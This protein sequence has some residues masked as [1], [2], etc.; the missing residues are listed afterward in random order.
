MRYLETEDLLESDPNKVEDDSGEYVA[1]KEKLS[2]NKTETSN[3]T[4]S[5][6]DLDA[7]FIEEP[8]EQPKSVPEQRTTERSTNKEEYADLITHISCLYFLLN[9]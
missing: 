9:Y 5:V 6:I 4:S 2:F 8:D 1:P 3:Q 7:D